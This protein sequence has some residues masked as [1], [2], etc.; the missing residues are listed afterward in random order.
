MDVTAASVVRLEKRLCMCF[1]VFFNNRKGMD[2]NILFT[3]K[4]VQKTRQF[5]FQYQ[6]NV[7]QESIPV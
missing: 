1:L 2:K 4:I 5:V 7:S 6:Q 3:P